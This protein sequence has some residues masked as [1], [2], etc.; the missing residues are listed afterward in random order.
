VFELFVFLC[1][2]AM[3]VAIFM[4]GNEYSVGGTSCAAPAVSAI[5]SLLNDVRIAQVSSSQAS[6]SC[7]HFFSLAEQAGAGLRLRPAL[8]SPRHL[9]RLCR[10]P[11][12]TRKHRQRVVGLCVL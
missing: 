12:R 4:G 7:F 8:L 2:V 9:A 1:S 11:H 3:N 6:A 10:H 5:L